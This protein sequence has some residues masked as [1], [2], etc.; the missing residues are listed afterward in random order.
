MWSV[1]SRGMSV[2]T[3]SVPVPKE[4]EAG[5]QELKDKEGK[6]LLKRLKPDL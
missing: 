4:V 1:E 6:A 2:V 3:S 5:D